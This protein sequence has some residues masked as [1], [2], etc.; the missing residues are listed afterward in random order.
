MTIKVPNRTRRPDIKQLGALTLP[1]AEVYKASNGITLHIV[2]CG[3]AEVN[4]LT[5]AL[6]GG[7]AESTQPGLFD[8]VAVLL[9]EGSCEHPGTNLSDLFESNGAWSGVSVTTHHTLISLSSLNSVFD[10]V[11]PLASEMVFSP[12]FED[13]AVTRALRLKASQIA[14]GARKVSVRASQALR[15]RIYGVDNPLSLSPT[16]EGILA[17]T[18]DDL[19]QAHFARLDTSGIHI[20]LSGKITPEMRE[21]VLRQFGSVDTGTTYNIPPLRFDPS[22]TAGIIRTEMPEAQQNSIKAA[23]PTPGR[24]D[25]DFLNLRLSTY[26]LGGYFGSR[27]MTS[28]REEKG[29]TYGISAALFAYPDNGYLVVSTDTDYSYTEAVIEAIT[30]EIERIKDPS[31]F[32]SDEVERVRSS[33]LTSLAAVLD[34]PMQRMDFLQSSIIADTPA[35]YYAR[36]IQSVNALSADTLAETAR[37]YFNTESAVISIAGKFPK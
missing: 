13:K 22:P 10:T 29:L 8:S 36:Q 15:P 33:L 18:P 20:F 3:T 32:T 19:R 5:I 11:M 14:L 4:R 21:S 23:I 16:P 7:T 6:P 26:A 37:R 28:I 31:T 34:T 17:L 2:S 30:A 27:L 24:R 25:S 12:S 9:P 35:D 1:S